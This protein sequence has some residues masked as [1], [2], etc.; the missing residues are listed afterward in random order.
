MR[1]L[2]PLLGCVV[3]FMSVACVDPPGGYTIGGRVTGLPQNTN[4]TLINNSGVD[5]LQVTRDG[6]YTFP[7]GLG[8]GEAYAV[9]VK[10]PQPLGTT[11]VVANPIGSID[12][13]SVTNADVTCTTTPETTLRGTVQK[14][15]GTLSLL[16]EGP[17]GVFET[18]SVQ[19]PASTFQFSR[20][21]TRGQPYRVAIFHHPLDMFCNIVKGGVIT[22][23]VEVSDEAPGGVVE[24][25]FEC[26]SALKTISVDVSGAKG[27]LVLQ[28][29]GTDT[30][31]IEKDGTY[32]F[33][34]KYREGSAYDL[35]V[36]SNPPNEAC[37]IP[38]G[39]GTL[40]DLN[41]INVRVLCSS[42]PG[43]LGL[44][45]TATTLPG[46]V[47]LDNAGIATV[48]VTA[49][50]PFA[51]DASFAKDGWYEVSVTSQPVGSVCEVLQRQPNGNITTVH[52]PVGVLRE[53]V[54][55]LSLSCVS[56]YTVG[57][58]VT[59]FAGSPNSLRLQLNDNQTVAISGNGSFT[60]PGL[61]AD[62]HAY[63]VAVLSHPNPNLPGA[64]LCT[65]GG[66]V[67]K[68]DRRNITNV[69][70]ICG[71]GAVS[72]YKV[73]GSVAGLTGSLVLKNGDF[74]T[75]TVATTP[76][77][78]D[79]PLVDQADYDVRIVAQPAGQF[80][81]LQNGLGQ[82]SGRDE[83]SVKVICANA[84]P[85]SVP[86]T[87]L[88][89]RIAVEVWA[90]IKDN[91]SILLPPLVA[92]AAGG[93]PIN[94]QYSVP[95]PLNLELTLKIAAA[96]VHQ[97]CVMLDGAGSLAQGANFA[98]R[99]VCGPYYGLISGQNAAV[100]IGQGDFTSAKC[101]ADRP[102][103]DANT[104]CNPW[105]NPWLDGNQLY[106]PDST[107]HRVLAYDA[108][109]TGMGAPAQRVIGQADFVSVL[110]RAGAAGLNNPQHVS[111]DASRLVVTDFAN[112]RVLIYA[113]SALATGASA[114]TV[115]GQPD[116][117]TT[118]SACTAT[119]LNQPQGAIIA[120][121]KL[122]VADTRNSRVLIWNTVPTVNGAP[123]DVVVGQTSMTACAPNQ[124]TA[125]PG[126]ST[127]DG[128]R[129]VWS[130]GDQLVIADSANNRVLL[131][132]T[133]PTGANAVASGV[134]GQKDFIHADAG[135]PERLS[136]PSAVA[137][138]GI[139]LFVADTGNHRVLVWN[140]LP[141]MM[142][143]DRV[144]VTPDGVLGQYAIAF[145]PESVNVINCNQER[146]R[147]GPATLCKPA[148][149]FMQGPNLVVG[150]TANNRYLIYRGF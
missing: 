112:S 42:P 77:D 120:N 76:F 27:P 67:G 123:A 144:N 58:T 103:A 11:C 111:G 96:P 145:T 13:A 94:P 65:V 66:G 36:A 41:L 51:F 19:A 132:K 20:T 82:I 64:Q 18:L 70:V 86:I 60:F 85:F 143:E 148:G 102:S 133:L 81:Y 53:D 129:D 119:G 73:G 45:G 49:P 23:S 98:H 37:V 46:P 92:T 126:N 140:D 48:T 136:V 105:G 135:L 21:I 134:L 110:R 100:A 146:L 149:I 24:I 7:R 8:D 2:R 109:P 68:V 84:F 38:Q 29:N 114:T 15:E 122:I 83:T 17:D 106:V 43:A 61:L 34:G 93:A 4:L 25:V 95:V 88:D 9:S 79:V 69:T 55:D 115:V 113:R 5:E 117:T 30:L 59:G 35:T 54:T 10:P 131:F 142:F 47:T 28:N 52:T 44:R 78:F 104:V 107:N 150:D 128:P 87:G 138:N 91:E 16:S 12:T 56:G 89:G 141:T 72:H 50:G 101:N 26:V 130:D 22:S 6:D 108:V 121:N 125:V 139:Q 63:S 32:T 127:L 80:C 116:F 33:A 90:S 39:A 118:A 62:Q 31:T 99:V 147:P 3:V 14:L 74:E 124:N 1:S 97:K 40:I 75:K 137:S 71:A 57:G